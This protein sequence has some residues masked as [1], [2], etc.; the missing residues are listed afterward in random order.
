MEAGS[1]RVEDLVESCP[2]IHAVTVLYPL[3]LTSHS[4]R[5]WECDL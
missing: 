4:T 2:V 1:V 3:H 5:L